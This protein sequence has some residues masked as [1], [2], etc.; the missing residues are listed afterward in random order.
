MS[1]DGF[2]I[3]S[4]LSS[5]PESLDTEADNEWRRITP[6]L[7][8]I[9][10]HSQIDHN[11]LAEYYSLWSAFREMHEDIGD[12]PLHVQGTRYEVEHPQIKPLQL[13]ADALML[14]VQAFG[15]TS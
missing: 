5:P 14:Q 11:A 12:D 13:T 6:Y 15:L 9:N 1:N 4:D 3:A 10:R 7:F 8:R 2:T